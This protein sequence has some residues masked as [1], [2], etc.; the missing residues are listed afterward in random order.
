MR[1]RNIA[2][3]RTKPHDT[4]HTR[5]ATPK[6]KPMGKGPDDEEQQRQNAVD[7]IRLMILETFSPNTTTNRR[8]MAK[9]EILFITGC[10]WAA[11]S[12]ECDLISRPRASGINISTIKRL[13]NVPRD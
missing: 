9:L 7:P 4:A 1:G 8:S 11:V 2:L 6:R 10:H 13:G 3:G 12:D 5:F